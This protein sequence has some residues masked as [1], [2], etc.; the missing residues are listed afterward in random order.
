MGLSLSSG[1]TIEP[2]TLTDAKVHLRIDHDDENA[3]VQNLAVASR[4]YWE[5][6][7]DRQFINAT[8]V[9]TLD[10]FPAATTDF[11]HPPRPPLSS[12]TSIQ[13]VDTAGD[14]QTWAAANYTTS[15]DVEPGRIGLAYNVD[16]PETREVM[17]AVTVTYVAGYGAAAPNVPEEARAL[18]LMRVADLYE[19][20]E[21]ISDTVG[22]KTITPAAKALM[23][24]LRVYQAV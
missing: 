19:N 17:D 9:Y 3:F 12:V 11:I 4:K 18:I 1:P 21:T 23:W 6:T 7:L 10:A 22:E 13:Y 20:R 16:W 24:A 8:W 14:T 5:A 2:V 15:T